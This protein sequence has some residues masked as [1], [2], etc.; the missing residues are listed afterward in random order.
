MKKEKPEFVIIQTTV[1][2]KKGVVEETAH[3][4]Q[5]SSNL[6]AAFQKI[7]VDDYAIEPGE[8]M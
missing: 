1:E 8:L 5:K 6:S 4:F 3:V 7:L 2:M